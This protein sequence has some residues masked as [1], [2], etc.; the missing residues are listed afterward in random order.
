MDPMSLISVGKEAALL[1]V[2]VSAPPVLASL[3]VGVLMSVVQATTQIQE[4]TISVV[5]KILAATLALSVAAPWIGS[6]LARFATQ[7]L[8]LIPGI[9]Q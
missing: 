3:V 6:Q 8:A 7:V 2:L 9:G 1:M 4:S 5:P